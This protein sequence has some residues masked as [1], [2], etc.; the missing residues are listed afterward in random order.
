MPR[1]KADNERLQE[2][3]RQKILLG[4]LE[5]FSKQGFAQ[6]TVDQI[7]VKAAV[8]KGLIYHYYQS[9]Q[10][11]LKGIFTMIL[12]ETEDF[13]PSGEPPKDYLKKL[14]AGS[15]QYIRAKPKM[16]RMFLSL[17]LQPDVVKGL[18]KEMDA[19]R[20]QFLHEFVGIFAAL[21]FEDPQAEAYLFSASLDGMA[22]GF[23]TVP[24]YPLEA[25]HLL[26]EKKYRLS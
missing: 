26:L 25:M 14:L 1:S 22:I 17:V 11:I 20:Q 24:D 7:A 3:S 16:N 8:S 13:M 2:K 9:K 18:K 15:I 19:F 10:E 12:K 21:G 6:T 5:L 23:L 4:A